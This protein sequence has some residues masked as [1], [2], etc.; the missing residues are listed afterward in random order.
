MN[1]E[2]VKYFER[3]DTVSFFP[4]GETEISPDRNQTK[5]EIKKQTQLQ[6]LLV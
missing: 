4:N 1:I 6:I 3:Y 5:S 2:T